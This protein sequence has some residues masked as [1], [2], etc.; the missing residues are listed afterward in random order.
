MA[1]IEI[2]GISKKYGRKKALKNVSIEISSGKS[3]GLFGP[4]GS[5]KTTL[6]KILS[7]M[8]R[9]FK[10]SIYVNGK[11]WTHKSKALMS[12]LPD[13]EMFEH[14]KPLKNIVR[15]YR[16]MFK[17]FDK[18]RF[19]ALSKRFRIDTAS[20][21]KKLSK[22]NK[23]KFQLALILSRDAHLYLFDE[24]IGGVDPAVRQIILDTIV[25]F[26]KSDATLIFS[27]HQLYDVE[28]LF[29]EV[30]FL[31]NGE[32]YLHEPTKVLTKKYNDTVL[33]IFKKVYMHDAY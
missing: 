3:I 26:R 25:E 13:C 27:T 20:H 1:E 18:E 23:E 2:R 28:N 22:G 32:I 29:D 19:D 6:I 30:I 21:F 14:S 5:G 10:G 11:K 31:R 15:Y 7:G 17:D 16:F 33:N 24:P 12:Y 9:K 8:Q 4:N